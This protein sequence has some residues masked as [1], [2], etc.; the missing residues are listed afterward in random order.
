MRARVLDGEARLVGVLAEVHLRAV[1]G[2][3]Q[4]HDVRAGAEDP[5]LERRDDDGVD[6]GMLEPEALN[7]VGELD[8][9]AEVVRVQL[10]LV[11]RRQPGVLA[12]VH[13]ERRDRRVDGEL[14]VAIAVG[15]GVK[16]DH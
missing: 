16:S 11:I 5:L 13:R 12:D 8:V 4:H 15:V 7:R 9:D 10:E 14:P 6:L 3:A 1:R 2:A